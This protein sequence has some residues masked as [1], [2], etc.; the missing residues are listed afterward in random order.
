M[1]CVCGSKLKK[2]K[3]DEEYFGGKVVLKGVDG[4]YCPKCKEELFTMQ[5]IIDTQKKVRTIAPE[6]FKTKKKVIKVGNSLALPISKDVATY[7]GMHKGDAFDIS[8]ES[9]K[10]LVVTV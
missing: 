10:K 7:V 8:I 4:Y 2:I 3:T 1:K 5:Q 6:F 9:R